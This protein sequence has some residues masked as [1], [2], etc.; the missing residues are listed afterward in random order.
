MSQFPLTKEIQ[1]FEFSRKFSTLIFDY[2]SR[3]S[4]LVHHIWHYWD[5]MVIYFATIQSCASPSLPV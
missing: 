2:Y 1:E 3:L 5:K 4:D